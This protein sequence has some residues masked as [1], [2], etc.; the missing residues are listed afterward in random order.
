MLQAGNV[1]LYGKGDFADVTRLRIFLK[2]LCVCVCVCVI[3][4]PQP[5]TN[6]QL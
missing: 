1:T 2:I 4:V 6:K 3:L 5:G